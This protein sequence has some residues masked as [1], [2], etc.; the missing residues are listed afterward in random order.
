MEITLLNSAIFNRDRTFDT[1][2]EAKDNAA[3]H[4][5][6]NGIRICYVPPYIH[7]SIPT[8]LR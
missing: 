2:G 1:G 6:A 4:L 8:Y 5:C 7:H 3:F